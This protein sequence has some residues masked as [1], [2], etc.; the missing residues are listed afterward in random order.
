[1]IEDLNMTS[2][3]MAW[4][5]STSL[6]KHP[7]WPGAK[8]VH[9]NTLPSSRTSLEHNQFSDLVKTETC[10]N[11]THE[12]MQTS[13]MHSL[14]CK[15]WQGKHITSKKAQCASYTWQEQRHSMH[16]TLTVASA[17]SQTSWRSAQINNEAKV[18]LD[19]VNLEHSTYANKDMDG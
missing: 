5:Y 4:S 8:R 15:S 12:G 2:K 18:E 13:S 10:W 6:I 9:K 3:N 1:M 16:G 17:K 14:R 19:W 11:L 7:K